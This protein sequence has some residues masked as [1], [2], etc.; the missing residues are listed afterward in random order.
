MKQM[1]CY[2]AFYSAYNLH[3]MHKLIPHTVS[4]NNCLDNFDGL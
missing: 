2:K 3:Q 4:D 1:Q